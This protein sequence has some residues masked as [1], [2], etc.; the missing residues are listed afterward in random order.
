MGSATGD[1]KAGPIS[2]RVRVRRRAERGSYDRQQAYDILDEA[3]WCRVAFVEEGQPYVLP[4][5][6][7]RQGDRL[8]IHGARANRMLTQVAA[9]APVCVEI[10]VVD[11]LAL[12]RSVMENSMNYRSVVILGRGSDVADPETKR[13]ALNALMDHVAPTRLPH[14]RPLND[15]ELRRTRVVSVPITEFSV[16]IRTG[17]A[18]DKLDDIDWRVWAGEVPLRIVP[19]TPV[20]APDLAAD[21]PVP[22]HI[23]A[24]GH[25]RR[26]V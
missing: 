10:T 13:V 20:P 14:L 5:M 22:E 2:D 9:G 18:K 1:P 7:I 15:S 19:G 8:L 4:T 21:V 6:H 24:W 12:G 16:K 3:L 25:W 26:G 17:P 11:S 23:S